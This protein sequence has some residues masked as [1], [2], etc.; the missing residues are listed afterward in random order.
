MSCQEYWCHTLPHPIVW[1]I[2]YN[3]VMYIFG[4]LFN[5][6]FSIHVLVAAFQ[7]TR[8]RHIIVVGVGFV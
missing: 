4:M 2:F 7:E 5:F 1:Y 3:K 8:S 6:P